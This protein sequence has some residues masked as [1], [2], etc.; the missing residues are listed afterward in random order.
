MSLFILLKI[1]NWL[2]FNLFT[3]SPLY[4]YCCHFSHAG[5]KITTMLANTVYENYWGLQPRSKTEVGI[6]SDRT[7]PDQAGNIISATDIT[8]PWK[9]LP[10]MIY[11]VSIQTYSPY[12]YLYISYEIKGEKLLINRV[13]DNETPW[14]RT[15]AANFS[16]PNTWFYYC[17][18]VFLRSY[19]NNAHFLGQ[20]KAVF[21]HCHWTVV[22]A[23]KINLD[24]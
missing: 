2:S 5:M 14:L 19:N 12:L 13:K 17:S 3:I 20:V 8:T 18:V 1:I 22:V 9:H 21:A 10:V 4:W 11:F 16:Q 7:R 24:C 23:K 6:T 15:Y